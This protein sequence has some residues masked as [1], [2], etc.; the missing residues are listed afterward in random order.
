MTRYIYLSGACFTSLVV[1]MLI[2]GSNIGES[3]ALAAMGGVFCFLVYLENKNEAPINEQVK[4]DIEELR[5]AVNA[6]K[7]EKAFRRA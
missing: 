7:V 2:C 1:R 4:K 6:L 3:V 5:S